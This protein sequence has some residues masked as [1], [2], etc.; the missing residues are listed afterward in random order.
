M[1][2]SFLPTCR[3]KNCWAKFELVEKTADGAILE[4]TFKS[5]KGPEQIEG[6][7]IHVEHYQ[8]NM[9]DLVGEPTGISYGGHSDTGNNQEKSLAKAIRDGK[10]AENP[11]LILL[12]LCAGLDG[13]DDALEN[14]GN[15]EVLTTVD[16]SYYG[17]ANLKDEDGKFEGVESYEMTPTLLSTWTSIIKGEDYTKMRRRIASGLESDDHVYHPNYV[18]PTLKDY[19]AMRWAISISMTTVLQTPSTFTFVSTSKTARAP[20]RSSQMSGDGRNQWRYRP[21][22][23]FRPK[24]FHPL[25][26]TEAKT[27]GSHISLSPV[28]SSKPRRVNLSSNSSTART[29]TES[30]LSKSW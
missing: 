3:T 9:F 12:D 26:R 20:T 29:A 13:L 14:L 18:T 21:R 17:K 30:P 23:R 22:C 11:Q 16:S 5:P 25:Q 28:A 6:I 7:R 27:T 4:A 2:R 15:V 1:Y 8:H 19:R 24:C 10:V